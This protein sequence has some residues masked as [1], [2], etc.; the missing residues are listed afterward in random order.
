MFAFICS[1]DGPM[2]TS[3]QSLVLDGPDKFFTIDESYC[4]S[5]QNYP[6]NFDDVFKNTV[7]YYIENVSFV[8]ETKNKD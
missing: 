6:L 5:M 4:P 8:Y 7:V 1:R 3:T 2:E